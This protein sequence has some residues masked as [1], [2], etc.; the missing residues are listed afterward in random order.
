MT[1]ILNK[2][3]VLLPHYAYIW[4]QLGK[5]FYDKPQGN[6]SKKLQR[7]Q[8]SNLPNRGPYKGQTN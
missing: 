4:V 6:R 1:N 8:G 3:V 7:T 2:Y 5:L